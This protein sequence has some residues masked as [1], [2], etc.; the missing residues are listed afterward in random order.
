MIT[1]PMLAGK[2]PE[3]LNLLKYPV[4]VTPKIDGIRCLKVGGKALTRSFKP[5][6]NIF[7]RKYIEAN[8]PNGVDGE[9]VLKGGTFQETTSAIMSEEGKPDFEYC[10]FDYVF[11]SSAISAIEKP[12]R[13]R[14]QELKKL[15]IIFRKINIL[16]KRILTSNALLAYEKLC[17][18]R[19]FEGIMIRDPE[20][21]YKCGRS[22]TKEGWLLKLKR[23]ETSEAEIIGFEEKMHNANEVETN[24]FGNIKRSSI[25]EN[26]VPLGVLGALIVK[27]CQTRLV[28]K[29]G[30]G[31]DASLQR[32]IW[33]NKD[34]YLEEIVTYRYQS[35]GVKELPR[36]PVFV[37]FR[38][39]TDIS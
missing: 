1:R 2:C 25:R 16:P 17:I 23:F 18:L 35:C 8:F 14:M 32:R 13:L 38:D 29:I 9:L 11:N 31:F 34:A 20:G 36:F 19:G 28:F 37:G 26:L 39:F 10:V 4:L 3:D 21:P 22:T 6:R 30:T 15:P 12:Y 27:D 33:Y 5:I 7:V 24:A